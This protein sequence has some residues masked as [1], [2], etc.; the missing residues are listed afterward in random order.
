M[1]IFAGIVAGLPN[2]IGGG[3]DPR[4]R[5]VTGAMR[6]V[7]RPDPHRHRDVGV[8][9]RPSSWCSWSVAQRRL[10]ITYAEAPGQG[11]KVYEW[12]DLVPA[13]EAQHGRRHSADLRF[14]ACM[15]LPTTIANWSR[16]TSRRHGAF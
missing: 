14:V 1:I 11:N 7:D 9:R 13:A 6:I 4:A 5:A 8:R 10:I 12:P 3:L 16:R 2:A 15:L